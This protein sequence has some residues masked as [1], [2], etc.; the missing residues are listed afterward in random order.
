[1]FNDEFSKPAMLDYRSVTDGSEQGMNK[2]IWE[3]KVGEADQP[4][5]YQSGANGTNGTVTFKIE[6]IYIYIYI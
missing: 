2:V 5:G 6:V 4:L 1:M 3:Q